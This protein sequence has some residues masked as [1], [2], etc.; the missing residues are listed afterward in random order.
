[1]PAL[2]FLIGLVMAGVSIGFITEM[3]YSFL[4]IGVGLMWG[5]YK[6]GMVAQ[7]ASVTKAFDSQRRF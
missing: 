2:I 7:L 6:A 5:G 1:M 3:V 4:F